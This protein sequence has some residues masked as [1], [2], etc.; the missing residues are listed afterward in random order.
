M[1]NSM[2]NNQTAKPPK[3]KGFISTAK[4]CAY[5][6]VFV[7][8]QIAV[9]FALTFIPGVELVTLLFVCYSLVMGVR[10]GVI[11]ATAFSLLRQL[12]FG[13]QPTVLVLYLIYF[14]LLTLI[15]GLIGKR[16]IA[17]IKTLFILVIIACVCTACFT[18]IDNILTPV[19]YGYSIKAMQ[20]YF[21]AGYSVST[22]NAVGIKFFTTEMLKTC[23]A[24]VWIYK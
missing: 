9:Q 24:F 7:A 22:C 12:V 1:L 14:N 19:W 3:N 21:N 2:P 16:L 13:F 18:L 5:L 20:V 23:K 10:R 6:A 17:S 8:L 4:E 15:F 11:S